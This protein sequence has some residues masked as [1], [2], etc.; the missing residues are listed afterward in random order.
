MKS[1]GT[2]MVVLNLTSLSPCFPGMCALSLSLSVYDV[3]FLTNAFSRKRRGLESQEEII[4]TFRVF[5]R[6]GDGYISESE[7][8]NIMASLGKVNLI[9]WD[10]I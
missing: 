9:E 3:C 10:R 5:D 2:G 4:E 6:D 7:L 1:M 8:R